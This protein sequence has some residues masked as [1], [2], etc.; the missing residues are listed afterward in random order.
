MSRKRDAIMTLVNLELTLV[1]SGVSVTRPWLLFPMA[2]VPGVLQ[3]GS[4]DAI[5]IRATPAI[6]F[7]L[8]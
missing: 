2:P 4:A 1:K 3:E 8:Y 7:V 5:I 6:A